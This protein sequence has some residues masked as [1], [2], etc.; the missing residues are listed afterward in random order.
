MIIFWIHLARVCA[1]SYRPLLNKV[2]VSSLLWNQASFTH[3]H[4]PS[5]HLNQCVQYR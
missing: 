5:T 2:F 4:I 3:E 1:L